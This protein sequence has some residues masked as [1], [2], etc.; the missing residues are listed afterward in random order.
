MN[1]INRAARV[2]KVMEVFLL[3]DE[4]GI[5]YTEACKEVGI[6]RDQFYYW[7]A[8]GKDALATFLQMRDLFAKRR[9]ALIEANLF[10]ATE[11][12]VEKA[13]DDETPPLARL[14]ILK[15]LTWEADRLSA[16]IVTA[17]QAELDAQQ[18]LTGPQLRP[19]KSR[20]PE[21]SVDIF[22]SITPPRDTDQ[23]DGV[24]LEPEE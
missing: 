17:H 9:L 6:S 11:K 5:S 1:E 20:L 15:Y 18:Y 21:G 3:H 8:E 19:G 12:L 23:I 16:K 4:K 7:Q 10:D 14:S 22:K 13:L 2:I 24:L